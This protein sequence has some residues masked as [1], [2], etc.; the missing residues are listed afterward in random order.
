MGR[1][2]HWSEA[3]GHLQAADGRL[4]NMTGRFRILK[5]KLRWIRILAETQTET[6][7]NELLRI[8]RVAR[9]MLGLSLPVHSHLTDEETKRAKTAAAQPLDVAAVVSDVAL[10]GGKH[11][12]VSWLAGQAKRLQQ[13]SLVAEALGELRDAADRFQD[14]R[15]YALLVRERCATCPALPPCLAREEG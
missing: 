10:L 2:E 14:F 8:E 6:G 12:T 7:R 5:L 4:R 13:N 15:P 9:E 3:L 1:P 11:E